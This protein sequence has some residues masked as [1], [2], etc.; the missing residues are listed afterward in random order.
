[1]QLPENCYQVYSS[2]QIQAAL[3][4]LAGRL[5]E[6]LHGDCPLVL[7]V[8]QGGLI[9][10]GQLLPRLNCLLEIDYVHASRYNNGTSGGAL[11]WIA[12][13]ASPLKGRTVLILDDILDEGHTLKAII[14]Y[15]YEQGARKVLSAVLLKKNHARGIEQKL[16]D[17]IALEVED[18]YVFGFG[19]DYEGQYR[20][21]D[22]IYAL[23]E[24]TAEALDPESD[25]ET[26]VEAKVETIPG[27]GNG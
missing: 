25:M 24:N 16:T 8:M 4:R 22:A 1:M 23:N 9:F 27:E 5:N 20:H 12:H 17:N 19:M 3:D 15:C 2:I 26:R 21:L 14:D 13:P 18:R 11:K 10:T 6:Q 7:C